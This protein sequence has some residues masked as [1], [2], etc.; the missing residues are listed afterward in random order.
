MNYI[1]RLKT[2]QKIFLFSILIV[3][4]ISFFDI[5]SM[6]SGIF[7]SQ[8]DY[9]HGNFDGL[10]WWPLFYNL[11]VGMIILLCLSYYWFGRKDFSESISLGFG[12]VILWFGAV[13]DVLFFWLRGIPVPSELPW[14]GGSPIVRSVMESLGVNIVTNITIYLSSV[15]SLVIVYYLT[16]F[17]VKKV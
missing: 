12:S 6:N 13:P 17:L 7:G 9:T 15:I 2:Y 8:E 3:V 10:N 4:A 16:K 1:N 5:L 11:N 14:L